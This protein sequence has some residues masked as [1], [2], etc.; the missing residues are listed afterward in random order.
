MARR[1]RLGVL[2]VRNITRRPGEALT[3]VLGAMLGTAVIVAAFVVG[4]SFSGSIRDVARTQLGPIDEQIQVRVDDQPVDGTAPADPTRQIAEIDNIVR[5]DPPAGTD[6]LIGSL[7]AAVVLGNGRSGDALAVLPTACAVEVDFAEGRRF[8]GDPAATGLADAGPNPTADQAVLNATAARRLEVSPGDHV[9]LTAFGASRTLEVRTVLPAVGLAGRCDAML[10]D[11]TLGPMYAARPAAA[12]SAQPPA[13]QLWVSNRGGVFDGVARTDAVVAELEALV[14]RSDHARGLTDIQTVKRDRLDSA[15]RQGAN[16]TSLFSGIGG[17]SVISGV[18]LVVNLFVMLAEERKVSIGVM[19]ALGTKRRH[20]FAG[21]VLEGAIYT[22]TATVAGIGA[23]IGVGWAVVRA[24]SGLFSNRDDD[25]AV[26][27]FVRPGS[28]LLAGGIGAAIALVTIAA[29]SLRI[30]RLNVIAAVRDLPDPPA[31]GPRVLRRAVAA[32]GVVLGL[33]TLAGGPAILLIAGVPVAAAGLALLLPARW[34][35]DAVAIACGAIAIGWPLAAFGL[36]PSRLDHPGISVFVVMGVLSV[37]GAVTIVVSADSAW[38]RLIGGLA[39]RGRGLALRLGLAYPLARR[40]RTGLLCAM[41]G[42]IVFTL[43]FLASFAAILTTQR[44]SAAGD[45]SA[46]SQLY[47]TSNRSNPLDAADLQRVDGVTTVAT[48]LRGGPQWIARRYQAEP[49]R[50]AASGIDGSFIGRGTPALSK[51]DERFADDRAAF[52]AVIEDP[53][54]VIVDDSFLL[55]GGGPKDDGAEV[56]DH[57]ALIDPTGAHHPLT[58]IGVLRSDFVFAGAFLQ[59]NA[60]ADWL[61]VRVTANQ[62][63]VGIA[64]GRDPASVAAAINAE[65]IDH[66][67]D[68][69]TFTQLVD[70][71]LRTTTGFIGLLEGYLAVGLIIGIA[72]LGVVMTRAV[73][74]RRREIGMLRSM[75]TSSSTVRAAFF[76]ESLVVTVNAIVIGVVLGLVTAWQVVVNSTAFSNATVS[77]VVPWGALWWIVA[78]PL[79]GAVAATLIPARRAARTR[80]AEALR[81]AD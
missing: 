73:R 5:H 46:G 62:A 45:M 53:T 72:G 42:L 12:A 49:T 48:T 26:S 24:T 61:G 7:Q 71:G 81:V 11:G 68:A 8:G 28:L 76:T 33:A 1:P 18:L 31:P 70:D 66:G 52:A 75:G 43:A 50:W 65:L 21:F 9:T 55:G 6:G 23:G 15:D 54:L 30:S 64:V 2:A 4:D 39:Q 67:A 37:A 63:Y 41:F 51:R 57:V 32:S 34:R 27:L 78:A 14:E 36:V 80:P 60:V 29:T 77:F 40:F 47:V 17:F 58:V 56:G 16:L 25:F 44:G 19:R 10:A 74:E 69:V 35:R 79:V 59:R 38:R 3:V 20:V 22:V 13:H